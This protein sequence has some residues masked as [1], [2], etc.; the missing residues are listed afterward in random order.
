[1]Q[2]KRGYLPTKRRVYQSDSALCDDQSYTSKFYTA[3]PAHAN[4][5]PPTIADIS[6]TAGVYGLKVSALDELV[7]A[8]PLYV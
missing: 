4:S 2:N 7:V 1:M 5:A 3:N 6:D 8:L